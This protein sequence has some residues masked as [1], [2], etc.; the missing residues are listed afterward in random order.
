MMTI[1]EVEDVG[2]SIAMRVGF[3]IVCCNESARR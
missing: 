1:E 2:N 3:E